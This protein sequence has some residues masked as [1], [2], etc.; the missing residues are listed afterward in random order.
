[1]AC[2]AQR[3]KTPAVMPSPGID[4]RV[5]PEHLHGRGQIRILGVADGTSEILQR[6]I[7]QQFDLQE[8]CTKHTPSY[9]PRG[10]AEKFGHYL[11]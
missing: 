9:R 3:Q 5:N 11:T 6:Q 8:D 7:A 2:P 10:C 4:W 1:V